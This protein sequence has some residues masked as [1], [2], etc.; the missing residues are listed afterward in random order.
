VSGFLLDTNVIS[1]VVNPAGPEP[2]VI[3]WLEG[4]DP[5]L[6]F[7]SVLTFG[8]IR[9]GIEKLPEGRRKREL[10]NWLETSVASWFGDDQILP[11]TRGIAERWAVLWAR[12][13]R[14][15][16]QVSTED[17]LIA[18]TALE[19]E[20][21]IVTRNVKHFEFVGV[22]IVNPWHPTEG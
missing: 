11:I 14:E 21:T 12:L 15:G 19:H 22:P 10:Q 7:V 3:A 9:R 13:R 20:L 2:A 8:E 16:F 1:E 17:G 5:K 4:A 6:L 18:A